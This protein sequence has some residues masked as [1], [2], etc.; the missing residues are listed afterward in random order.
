M[1][2]VQGYAFRTTILESNRFKFQYEEL[3]RGE[4]IKPNAIKIKV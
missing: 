2:L 1:L 4:Q 3:E